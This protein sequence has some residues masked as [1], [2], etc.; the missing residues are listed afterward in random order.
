MTRRPAT[1]R[2]RLAL[3]GATLLVAA[4]VAL[5][6][7][8]G[9]AGERAELATVD[10]R[11]SIRGESAPPRDI[12]VVAIDDVTFDELPP[13]RARFPF[14]RRVFAKVLD[15]VAAARPRAIVYDVQFTEPQGDGDDDVAA[16]NALIEAARRAGRV[17]FSS[18]EVDD[19]GRTNVFGGEEGQAY[20]GALLGNGLLPQGRGGAVRRVP[21]AVDG[22]PTLAVRAVQRL[23]RPARPEAFEEDGAWIDFHGE[24]GRVPAV[25]FSRVHAGRLPPETFRDRIVVIGATAPS[26][27]DRH[28]TSAGSS[29]MAGP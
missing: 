19:R 27:Q 24:P 16:D 23:G 6:V 4:A 28:E 8:A 12:V 2:L 22:L 21:S 1:R 9:V 25:S 7:T 18:T 14:D 11:F 10:A 29:T 15:V 5:L 26:L 3:L 20:A 13:E 17:V